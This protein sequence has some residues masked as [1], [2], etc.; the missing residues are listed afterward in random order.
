MAGGA[1]DLAAIARLRDAGVAG[2]ILG[3]VLLSG[4][5]DYPTAVEAAA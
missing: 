3:E 1:A 4:A 2:L 5:I